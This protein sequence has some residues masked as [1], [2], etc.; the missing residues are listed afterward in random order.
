VDFDIM[1]DDVD[2]CDQVFALRW[3][4][5]SSEIYITIIRFERIVC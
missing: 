5:A 1:N 4:F 2:A 3:L